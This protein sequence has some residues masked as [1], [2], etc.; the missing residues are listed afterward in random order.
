MR[1]PFSSRLPPLGPGVAGRLVR[2]N[3]NGT[4]TVIASTDW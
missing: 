2:V 1:H 4:Q 3:S